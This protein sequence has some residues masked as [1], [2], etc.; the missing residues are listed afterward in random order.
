MGFEEKVSSLLA[1]SAAKEFV[2]CRF[3]MIWV[4]FIQTSHVWWWLYSTLYEQNNKYFIFEKIVYL[5]K[6]IMLL[7]AFHLSS[8]GLECVLQRN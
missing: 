7:E 1:F 6:K 8:R 3:I 2:G 5:A 4:H